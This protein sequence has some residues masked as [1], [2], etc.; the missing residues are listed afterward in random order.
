MAWFYR[1]TEGRERGP[2]EDVVLKAYII[3]GRITAGTPVR[4]EDSA[5]WAAAGETGLAHLFA[6][7]RGAQDPFAWDASEPVTLLLLMPDGQMANFCLG[8][9]PLVIGSAGDCN[10][11][12]YR[13]TDNLMFSGSC[14]RAAS[15]ISFRLPERAIWP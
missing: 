15:Q 3:Q 12:M 13:G 9:S 1:D 7:G 2:V 4:V 8:P 6:R 5:E 14:S 10:V 11:V